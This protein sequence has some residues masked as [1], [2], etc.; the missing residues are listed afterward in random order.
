MQTTHSKKEYVERARAGH[1]EALKAMLPRGDS[2]TGLQ[3]WRQLHR[4]ERQANQTACQLCNG[5]IE[6][7]MADNVF[8]CISKKVAHLFNGTLPQGFFIN[9]DPRGWALKLEAGS[10]PHKLHEDWGRYQILAPEID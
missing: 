1:H 8:A 2:R 6:Q 4:L 10:V 7:D 3:L 5:E 9:R